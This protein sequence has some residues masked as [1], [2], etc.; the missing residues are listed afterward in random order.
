MA[1]IILIAVGNLQQK[2]FREAADE[3]K[4]R[5]GAHYRV[6]ETEI[7]EERLPQN[8]SKSEI[9]IAL[10]KEAEKIMAAIPKRSYI[11]TLCIEGKTID[12]EEFSIQLE[13]ASVRG[14]STF[15]FIIGSS[16][17]LSEKIKRLSDFK[18]SM[19]K[20]TFP[21]Q[22]ARVMLYEALYR[23]DEIRSGTRYHK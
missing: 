13:Q 16:Y 19:S 4:K 17:G 14:F 18:L 3:Y 7:K 6:I 12:S 5:L 22:L 1:D 21:H 10:E 20:M 23:S 2:Y 11:T 9:S 15:V 8:P